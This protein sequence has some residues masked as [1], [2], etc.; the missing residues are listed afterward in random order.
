[1]FSYLVNDILDKYRVQ[2]IGSSLKLVD[3][4]YRIRNL[5]SAFDKILDNFPCTGNIY[6][7][8]KWNLQT[9]FE[10]RVSLLC[11]LCTN[12]IRK[13]MNLPLL[14]RHKTPMRC[15]QDYLALGGNQCNR[16]KT[17]NL[18]LSRRQRREKKTKLF[19]H[20]SHECMVSYKQGSKILVDSHEPLHLEITW[21]F[22]KK[23]LVNTIR[24]MDYDTE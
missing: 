22:L 5:L 3:V 21:H 11:S 24:K 7:C 12:A 14:S 10:F 23:K 18:K 8:D 1:M 20:L 6:W 4:I 19:N 17:L 9:E 15:R 13:V 16:R 2:L